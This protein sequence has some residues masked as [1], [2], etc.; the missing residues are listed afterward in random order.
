MLYR[1]FRLVANHSIHGN[2]CRH[3]DDVLRSSTRHMKA[4]QTNAEESERDTER[5]SVSQLSHLQN[6]RV[7]PIGSRPTKASFYT[8]LLFSSDSEASQSAP[9]QLGSLAEL[10]RS[11]ARQP[12]RGAGVHPGGQPTGIARTGRDSGAE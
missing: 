8:S 11:A 2:I 4:T 1:L 5:G 6:V 10:S 3:L 12:G 9:W 7:R